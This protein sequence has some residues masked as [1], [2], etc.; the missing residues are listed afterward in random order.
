DP[1]GRPPAGGAEPCA[2]VTE[3]QFRPAINRLAAAF[4]N[5]ATSSRAGAVLM[6]DAEM[7]GAATDP[8][9]RLRGSTWRARGPRPW[10]RP[11]T[12][13]RATIRLVLGAK[14]LEQEGFL[15]PAG[16]GGHEQANHRRVL[17]EYWLAK[18]QGLP[19]D[20]PDDGEI[21]RVTHEPV[22]A[23]DHQVLGRRHRS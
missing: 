8:V 19:N 3:L 10:A 17:Q 7:V 13:H 1:A 5:V 14:A 15:D 2:A 23:T 18:K 6:T 12:R 20:R 4:G 22:H 9:G 16:E 11:P 21:H